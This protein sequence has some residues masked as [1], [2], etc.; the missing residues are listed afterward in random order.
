MLLRL[1]MDRR[2]IVFG[3]AKCAALTSMLAV[4]GCATNQEQ[5]R[6][7]YAR[8]AY[9]QRTAVAPQRAAQPEV[10]DDGLPSQVAPPIGRRTE[11]DDP[12]QP[13]SPNY[14]RIKVVPQRAAAV[15]SSPGGS[16]IM[17]RRVATY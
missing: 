4:A 2:R 16:A 8:D 17:P 9:A 3:A 12:S 5:R 14:G 1:C 15:A 13:Y 10:E 6:D 7:A 11:P